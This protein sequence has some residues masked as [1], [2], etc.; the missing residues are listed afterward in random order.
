MARMLELIQQSAVPATVMRNAAR[1]AL[2]LPPAEVLEILVYLSS[3]HIFGDQAR[4]TLAGF[5]ES[6][7]ASALRTPETPASVLNYFTSPQNVR[8]A[9]IPALLDNP[10]LTEAAIVQLCATASSVS[11]GPLL[12]SPRV[13]ESRMA[14]RALAGNTHVTIEQT[15]GAEEL[16]KQLSQADGDADDD[17]AVSDFLARHAAD[18][19]AEGDK[20]FT[21]VGASEIEQ[22]ALEQDRQL[23]GF[24]KALQTHERPSPIQKIARLNVGGRVQLAMKGS[25]D[26]RAILIR[27]GARIV[28]SAVL[29]SPKL[30]ESEVDA[31]AA[32]K[33]IGES[34]LR[35]IGT[36]RKFLKRY[37]VVRI[38]CMN[39]KTPIDVSLSLIPRL[40]TNDLKNLTKNRDVSDTVAKAAVKIFRDRTSAR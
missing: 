10:N 9:L 14:L 28:S 18:I 25:K 1:G 11:A 21:L 22:Q 38:L 32:L 34:V 8:P 19:A 20:P 4:L 40:T 7:T 12:A 24:N 37:N 5:D 15:A 6:S 26:E 36:K 35:I 3:H 16:L 33:N 39:P 29:E 2:S 31:F 30:T 23:V 13:H 17:A 27:D